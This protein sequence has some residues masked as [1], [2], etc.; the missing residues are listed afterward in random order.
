MK[1]FAI[2]L[3]AALISAQPC[4][5]YDDDEDEVIVSTTT[6]V[7][8]NEVVVVQQAPTYY[9]NPSSDVFAG[10]VGMAVGIG[11]LALALG[12]CYHCGH[13]YPYHHHHWHH[14]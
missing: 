8:P 3:M 2:A 9:S 1:S 12:P 11:A 5:A 6:T 10:L 14:W 13:Y 4:F 7:V